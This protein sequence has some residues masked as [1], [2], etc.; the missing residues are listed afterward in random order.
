MKTEEARKLADQAVCE[1]AEQLERGKSDR[2]RDYLR[3]MSRFRAY[4]MGNVLLIAPQRPDA[5]HV[6]GYRTWQALGRQVKAGEHGIVILS[7][8]VRRSRVNNG[9]AIKPTQSEKNETESQPSL[10]EETV[11]GFRPVHVFDVA[12]TEG[13]D[14]PEF[15]HAQGDPREHMERLKALI[16]AE[17]ITLEYRQSLGGADGASMD[18]R[19]L[20]RTGMTPAEEFSVLVHEAAHVRMHLKGDQTADHAVRETEAEAVAFVVCD[21][22]GVESRS[23]SADYIH[24]HQ[25][26]RDLLLRSL[27]R[28]QRT[29]MEIISG[30]VGQTPPAV[31]AACRQYVKQLAAPSATPPRNRT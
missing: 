12:Q 18:G 22:V 4:S 24:L 28:I 2:L 25:G 27:K 1:L 13:R 5:T 14:L 7:P 3:T 21:A 23:A 6:A 17:G 26:D 8:I 10:G 15:A 19:I 16:A 31:S 11:A 30:I 29:A 20:I 9:K